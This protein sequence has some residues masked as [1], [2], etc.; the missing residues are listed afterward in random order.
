MIS[1]API[2]PAMEYFNFIFE[3]QINLKI[4]RLQFV[5]LQKWTF[6]FYLTVDEKNPLLNLPKEIRSIIKIN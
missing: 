2:F 4:P 5:V 1:A 3:N 6:F